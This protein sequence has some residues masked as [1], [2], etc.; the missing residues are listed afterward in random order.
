MALKSVS[1]RDVNISDLEL[2]Y[3]CSPPTN[4]C[5]LGDCGRCPKDGHFTLERLGIPEEAGILVEALGVRR[6]DK[7]IFGFNDIHE[8][9]S[10]TGRKMDSS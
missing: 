4:E 10:D 1:G 5:R 9:T 6:S 2:L 7:K 8:R 3:I